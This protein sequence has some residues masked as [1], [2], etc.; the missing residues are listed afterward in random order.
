[1]LGTERIIES[2]TLDP[3]VRSP[4]VVHANCDA[5]AAAM[6]PTSRNS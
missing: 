6:R 1:M 3:Y 4:S 5:V 2:E